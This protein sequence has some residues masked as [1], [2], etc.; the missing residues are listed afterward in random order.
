LANANPTIESNETPLKVTAHVNL[1]T[2]EL[3]YELHYRRGNNRPQM[4][5]FFFNGNLP[6]AIDRARKHCERMDYRFCGCYPFAVDLD[7]QEK[8]RNDAVE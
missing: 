5:V 1:T 2:K 3:A 7:I 6:M 4:K 8:M